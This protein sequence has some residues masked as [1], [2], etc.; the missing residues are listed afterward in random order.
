MS[1][2]EF[3]A[4]FIESFLSS[5]YGHGVKIVPIEDQD[6]KSQV[7]DATMKFLAP[8]PSGRAGIMLIS[9][10]GNP[11]LVQRGVDNIRAARGRV[12]ERT[13]SYI[14]PPVVSGDMAGR[15]FAVWERKR[16]FLTSNRV[17]RHLRNHAYARRIVQWLVAFGTESMVPVRPDAVLADLHVIGDDTGF[18]DD[19]RRAADRA[20]ARL[21]AGR[22]RPVSC[23]QH[24]DFWSGNLLLPT[25]PGDAPFFV[26]DWAGLQHRGYPFLDLSRALMSLRCSTRFNRNSIQSLCRDTGCE[27]EDV[28]SYILSACGRLGANL[29]HFPVER[30]RASTIGLYRFAHSMRHRDAE[31]VHPRI[32]CAN[33]VP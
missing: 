30:F 18:P 15:T 2:S 24:G 31:P 17:S 16:P 20:A 8:T 5:E 14:L 3:C 4:S 33:A 21:S 29:E 27:T 10:T 11:Q 6:F 22:W 28:A 12:S 32:E 1:P 9:G 19:I 23:L 7:A 26:I 13:G 25:D